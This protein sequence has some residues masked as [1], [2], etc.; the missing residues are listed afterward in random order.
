MVVLEQQ[1]SRFGVVLTGSDVE[2]RQADFTF[3]VMFQEQ[4]DHLIMTLLQ[5]NGKRSE[6]ILEMERTDR[7]RLSNRTDSL[8]R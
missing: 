2:C 4:R 3:R 1:S 7:Q 8:F 5:S 6:S